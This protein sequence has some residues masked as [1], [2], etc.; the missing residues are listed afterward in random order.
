M[1]NLIIIASN[2]AH[3]YG[4][5]G[6]SATR[7]WPRTT[8]GNGFRGGLIPPCLRLQLGNQRWRGRRDSSPRNRVGREN[9]PFGI[10]ASVGGAVQLPCLAGRPAFNDPSLRPNSKHDLL[11]APPIWPSVSKRLLM[12][13]A[14]GCKA[15]LGSHYLTSE[16]QT[17]KDNE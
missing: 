7:G 6:F 17:G 8:Y 1:L 5:A 3:G 16:S 12:A 4:Q 9:R 2:W 13:T 14:I 10:Q 11:D 15:S